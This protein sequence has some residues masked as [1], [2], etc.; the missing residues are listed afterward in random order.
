[1]RNL[2]FKPPP[3]MVTII[4]GILLMV[5]ILLAIW[6][7][8]RALLKDNLQKLAVAHINKPIVNLN[9]LNEFDA[10]ELLWRRVEVTGVFH[11]DLEFYIDNRIHNHQV[12][13]HIITPFEVSD[14][15]W[16]LVNRG[17]YPVDLKRQIDDNIPV[18]SREE[19]TITG[20]L[21][22]D[23]QDA[24]E[25]ADDLGENK[26]WQNL[27]ITTWQERTNKD[28]YPF[29]LLLKDPPKEIVEVAK[30][31][32]YRAEVSRGYRLQWLLLSLVVLIGW[33]CMSITRKHEK[34]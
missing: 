6:Q 10:D 2:K 12:G 30:K 16:L 17:W 20:M 18:A 7:H 32:D 31:P 9:A 23:N 29:V 25:L 26:I 27:K 1:M 34:N 5:T 22:T 28:S 21:T 15:Y 3:L 11:N 24:F 14:K 8:Q 4:C 19:V 13:V 33:L